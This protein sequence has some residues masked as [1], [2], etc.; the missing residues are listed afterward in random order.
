MQDTSTIVAENWCRPSG[1]QWPARAI[2]D[3]EDT[4][5]DVDEKSI[6]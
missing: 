6:D 1:E 3:N 5:S 4:H 2:Y